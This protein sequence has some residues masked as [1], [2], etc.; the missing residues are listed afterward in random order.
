ML[1]MA[2]ASLRN[3]KGAAL[4][5]LLALFFAAAMVGACGVLLETGL[6]GTIAPG[7]FAGA[8]VV[9]TGDQQIH[10]VNSK[11]KHGK[12]KKKIK[13]KDLAE[14]VWLPSSIGA[15]VG[16]I[17]GAIV[18]IDRTFTV[19]LF[20]SNR[21][22][23]DEADGKATYGHNWS[24][25][26]LTPYEI[27]SGQAPRSNTD[28]VLSSGL[29][30]KAAL[31]VGDRIGVQSTGS[32]STFTVSGIA[33]AQSP[34]TQEAAIFFSESEAIALA[35]HGDSAT[36]YG[37]FGAKADAVRNALSGS[38]AQVVT[39]DN[40]G[41]AALP[42]ASA[43]K[44]RLISM[45]GAI[46][47]TALVVAILVVIGTFTLSIQQRYREMALLRAIGATPRQVRRLINREALVLG[48]LAGVTGAV[49]GL[50]LANLIHR[51]FVSSGTVP[52]AIRVA[53]SPL[54]V[55]ASALVT[56]LAAQVASRISTRRITRIRPAEALSEASIQPRTIAPSRTV[57]G[58]VVTAVAVTVT[59]VLT[60]LHAEPAALPTTYLCVLLWMI[61]LTLLG[62][63]LARAG[64]AVLGI[65]SRPSRVGGFLATKNSQMYSR[66]MASA[67]TPLALLLAMTATVLFVPSTVETAVQAQTRDG[68]SAD[69][70]VA[71]SGPGVPAAAAA[72]IRSTNGVSAAVSAVAST[73]WI[74]RDKRSAQGLSNAGLTEII[75]PD[76][77]SG[78][79]A[80]LKDGDIA[81]SS[82]SAHGR[83]VGDK[84]NGT[85]GDG[86]KVLF[87]LVAIYRRGLGFG[88]T[89]MNFDQLVQHVNSP[90][91]QQ[92]FIKGSL[93]PNTLDN[94]LAPY[95][96]LRLID[97]SGY[98]QVI[99]DHHNANDA[100]NLAFLALIIAFCGIAV[101]NTLVMATT[102][103]TREFSLL[104]LT[105]ATTRQVRSML[106]WELAFT[107]VLAVVL[108]VIAS[109]S[110]LIGFSIGMT[111]A[112]TPT[113]SPLTCAALVLCA[114]V[115]GVIAVYLPAWALLR[116]NP[117][118]EMTS[119]Q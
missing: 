105:G 36:A 67:L 68:L 49:A 47:G 74:G 17:P 7:R 44:T 2:L 37:V 61:G 75:N 108:A 9:V 41:A 26:Q 64:V 46:G 86:T 10:W 95:P 16:T 107:V 70:V 59:I 6:R 90:L 82:L 79:L 57:A 51:E 29:A 98:R 101:I 1:G 72:R 115:L 62:P 69:W 14:R 48:L 25:A 78:T 38:T 111:D 22:F 35:R 97:R 19:E 77:T 91:A 30:A 60:T 112:A 31:V 109:G 58:I 81:M 28:I 43:A 66:R 39:G 8:A 56:L 119:T 42:G 40:R 18:V 94:E 24:A 11:D 33:R 53:R 55:V 4:G 21:T 110:T 71:S 83:H 23:I 12:T 84:V 104:R 34:V 27:V 113:V 87:V 103:R 85:L 15:R 13:S 52:D 73:V 32:P 80:K 118:D 50:P 54:P 5:S 89:L 63:L 96:G 114:V 117:A 3:R 92:V 76:V 102:D 116:R 20:R 88:D 100:A 65:V 106:G 99:S 93:D 45:S